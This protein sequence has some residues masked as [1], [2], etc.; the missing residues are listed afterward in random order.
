MTKNIGILLFDR[1]EE[2]DVVGP[3]EVLAAWTQQYPEDG[4][5]VFTVSADGE[6]VTCAKRMVL[7][8]DHSFADSPG[9][10]VLIHPGGEGT[11]ELVRDEAHLA[12]L[13][14]QR[15]GVP[16]L[17]SVCTGS[18]VYA[19]AGLL[20]GRPA[21]SH[22]E[23]VELLDIIDETIEVR[24]NERFVDDGDVIT[25]A[26]VSAGID[27]ALHLVS[28]LAGP[29]RSRAVRRHIQYDVRPPG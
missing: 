10:E 15:A 24:D 13:R 17:A 26:G 5:R 4:Y 25:A 2:L 20:T 16:L 12:W 7:T 14:D 1:V 27:M 11:D 18:L 21:T 9:W 19:A 8:P 29:P 6:P 28:R 23:T 3:W 22:W